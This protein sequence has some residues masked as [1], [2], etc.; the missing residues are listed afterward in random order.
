M[1]NKMT[2]ALI[3]YTGFVGS[4]LRRSH[5]FQACF[6]SKNIA[7]IEGGSFNLVVCAGAPA[8]KWYANQHPDEDKAVIDNLISHLSKIQ[9]NRFVLISTVDVFKSPVGVDENSPIEME[10]L[11]PYG[12]NRRRLELFVQQQFE[13]SL[14]VRLPGLVGQGLKKNILFD[15]LNSNQIEKIDSRGIFQFYPMHR[16]W[17]DIER[18]IAE[19]LKELH[20]T[21]AP[22]SVKD[23]AKA[24]FDTDFCN[25]VLLKPAVYDFRS[26]HA[27]LWGGELYQYSYEAELEAIKEWAVNEPKTILGK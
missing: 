16:L 20:L 14:I 27:H 24:V 8:K 1:D 2:D 23:I 11:C 22:V 7:Q 25:E 26:V 18:A 15:F 10:G 6:N 3:G 21:S 19:G 9:A 4:T 5:L 17:M 12:L 13:Q